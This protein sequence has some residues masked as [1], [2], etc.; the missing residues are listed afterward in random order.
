MGL[1][2]NP[3]EGRCRNCGNTEFT[4]GMISTVEA[5]KAERQLGWRFIPFMHDLNVP[6]PF[7][8]NN[9]FIVAP[10]EKVG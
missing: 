1:I 6:N 3:Y 8:K 2:N 10:K 9:I 5:S 7:V 4:V